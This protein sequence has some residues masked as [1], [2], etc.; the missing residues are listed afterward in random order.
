[1]STP[2]SFQIEASQF[3]FERDHSMVFARMGTGKTL[4]Y[5]LAMQ[6]WIESGAA[7]RIMVVAPL[8]VV[9]N[10][11]QQER[12]KWGIPLTMSKVTGEQTIKQNRAAVEAPTQVLLV[13]VEMAIKLVKEGNHGCD[14]IV[15]D[16]LS[17][18][19]NGTGKRMREM[20]KLTRQGFGIKSGGTG[21]PAPNGLLSLYGM[22]ATVGLDMFG[23]NYDKWL[24]QYFWP[25]DYEQR[26]WIPFKETPAALA[27]ILKPW[28]YVL[29]END[30]ELPPVVR[31][32]IVLDLPAPLRAQYDSFRRTA[33]MTDKEIMAANNGVLR[34][35]LRQMSCGFIYGNDSAPHSLDRFR[36]DAIEDVIAEQQG[37][38]IIIAYEYHE[39]LAMML[40]RWPDLPW[41]GGGSTD[42]EARI[43][44]WNAG[45]LQVLALH[46]AAAGHGLNLQGG[47]NAIVWWQLPDDLEL[48]DQTIGRLRR[49][50]QARAMVFSYELETVKTIDQAVAAMAIEK[51]TTQDGLWGALRRSAA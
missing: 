12:D 26:S 35:K 9:N 13:N 48:Y 11:W 43:K 16:E 3:V 32:P 22:A 29:E 34:G 51:G 27:D 1:M 24:R 23:R 45:Q 5:L 18:W 44:A 6:D 46:P 33:V 42:T 50:D 15:F 17:R 19:R 8:R 4:T 30:V 49:R 2:A 47:G 38:P 40:A 37:A 14:A 39:Q 7:K 36:L 21:T 10:V 31:T 41:I 28:T 20:R 25:E